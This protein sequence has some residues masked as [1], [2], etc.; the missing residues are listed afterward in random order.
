MNN[1]WVYIVEQQSKGIVYADSENEAIEKVVTSY[2]KHNDKIQP[3]CVQV[4]KAT[5]TEGW[6]SDC[7]DMLEIVSFV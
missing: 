3:N 2:A 1:V 4:Y 5:E 6:K 7:P